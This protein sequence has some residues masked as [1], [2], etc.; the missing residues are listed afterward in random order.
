MQKGERVASEVNLELNTV[1]WS[2]YARCEASG[3][4]T[5]A[6]LSL[7]AQHRHQRLHSTRS[8]TNR[9]IEKHLA[10]SLPCLEKV[11]QAH[12]DSNGI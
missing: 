12:S 1:V 7:W 8:N 6:A 4:S 2:V 10:F 5:H 3:A 11:A 9:E